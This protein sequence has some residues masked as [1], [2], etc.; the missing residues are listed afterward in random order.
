MF[1]TGTAGRATRLPS[2]IALELASQQIIRGHGFDRAVDI[3]KREYPQQQ[4]DHGVTVS[5]QPIQITL[6]A[7]LTHE[8]HD[9]RAAIQWRNRQQIEGAQKQVERKESPQHAARRSEE[10]TSEL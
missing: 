10:H 5:P 7:C 8:Q 1:T 2:T 6:R 9:G 3:T 4:A